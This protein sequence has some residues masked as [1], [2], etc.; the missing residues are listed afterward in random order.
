M[1]PPDSSGGGAR[2]HNRPRPTAQN[3]A[4]AKPQVPLQSTATGRQEWRDALP[5]QREERV[6]ELRRGL[7][8]A[9]LRSD[10]DLHAQAVEHVDRALREYPSLRGVDR[11]VYVGIVE[12]WMQPLNANRSW[13]RRQWQAPRGEATWCGGPVGLHVPEQ[14]R[15]A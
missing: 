1:S 5:R 4:A 12:Q 15:P 9:R 8:D 3:A 7:D 14:R 10:H 13:T 11:A 2:H 6:Q